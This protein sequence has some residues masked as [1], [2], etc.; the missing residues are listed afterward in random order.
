MTIFLKALGQLGVTQENIS[1]YDHI[2]V[3]FSDIQTFNAS[4]HDFPCIQKQHL[5]NAISKV[6]YKIDVSK[7]D[8]FLLKKDFM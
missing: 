6:S 2:K 4:M 1:S 7:L 8:H 5:K 3:V